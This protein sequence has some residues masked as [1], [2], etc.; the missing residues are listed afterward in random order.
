VQS[1]STGLE[2]RL[3]GSAD[4]AAVQRIIAAAFA[5]YEA[6]LPP[7]VFEHY[8]EDLLAVGERMD[9]ADVLVATTDD[10]LVG[11]VTF[12]DDGGDLGMSWPAGC[13]VFRA[14]AVTR[15]NA[16]VAPAGRS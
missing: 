5:Q 12:Y 10:E 1:T 13:G 4:V 7:I 3:A 2:I 16:P 9:H 6:V 14:V 11:T 15:N 8:L